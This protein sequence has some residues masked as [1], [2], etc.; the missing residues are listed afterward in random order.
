MVDEMKKE[1]VYNN[2]CSRDRRHPMW[3]DLWG[4]EDKEDIPEPREKNCFCHNC[5]YG[6]D[7]L[8][9]EIIRL[10]EKELV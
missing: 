2:L 3:D 10:K 5:F 9:L 7:A 1:D 6:R 8:A 4:Y